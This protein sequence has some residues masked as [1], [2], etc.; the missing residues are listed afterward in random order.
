MASTFLQKAIIMNNKFINGQHRDTSNR[1]LVW[2]PYVRDYIDFS[3][4]T[5]AQVDPIGSR[6][7]RQVI[8]PQFGSDSTSNHDRPSPQRPS[9]RS[10]GK[11]DRTGAT[12]PGLIHLFVQ[13]LGL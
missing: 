6:Y 13:A 3:A 9:A 4:K 12:G 8:A 11:L 5:L 7:W 1:K 2:D 10:S